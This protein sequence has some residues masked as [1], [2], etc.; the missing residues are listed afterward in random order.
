MEKKA[1]L[2]FQYDR[3]S[4]WHP[5]DEKAKSQSSG[6]HALV[7]ASAALAAGFMVFRKLFPGLQTTGPAPLR[8][9]ARHPW[10][11]PMLIGAGVG[12]SVGMQAMTAPMPLTKEGG[13]HRLDAKKAGA[14]H[15]AIGASKSRPDTLSHGMVTLAYVYS[16]ANRSN[17]Q[18]PGQYD[19]IVA[20]RPELASLHKVANHSPRYASQDAKIADSIR[21]MK[22]K[23]N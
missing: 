1:E 8:A 7:P 14:Y 19:R 13:V 6:Q 18:T 3:D 17:S 23:R 16:N 2:D 10:L 9:I 4:Q 22:T 21:R 5:M 12:A 20:Q 15:G 11:L